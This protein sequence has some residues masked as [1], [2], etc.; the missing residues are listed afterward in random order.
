[1]AFLSEVFTA[2]FDFWAFF[3]YFRRIDFVLLKSIC[4]R[5]GINHCPEKGGFLRRCLNQK[6][7]A[8][9]KF[10]A[11][12]TMFIRAPERKKGTWE[13]LRR[14]SVRCGFAPK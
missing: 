11:T 8:K 13:N 10:I 2:G 1:L 3:W 9:A 4:W 7:M 12:S 6:R 14:F 5:G